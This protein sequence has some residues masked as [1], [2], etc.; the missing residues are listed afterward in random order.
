MASYSVREQA[1]HDAS[2]RPF[3]TLDL[4]P[5]LARGIADLVF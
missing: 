3:S 5:A 1:P 4:H 2:P